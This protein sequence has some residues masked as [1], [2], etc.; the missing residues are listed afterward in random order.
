MIENALLHILATGDNGDYFDGQYPPAVVAPSR[1]T[2]IAVQKELAQLGYYH[3]PV[4]GLIG[5]ETEGAIRHDLGSR[6]DISKGLS[7][8]DQIITSPP[9][10]LSDGTP[11]IIANP[12]WARTLNITSER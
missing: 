6:M 1:E 9:P 10:G 8:S 11:V 5:P 7:E 4:D 2:I 3:G 12:T